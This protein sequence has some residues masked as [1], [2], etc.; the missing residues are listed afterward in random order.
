MNRR[1]KLIQETI[2]EWQQDYQEILTEK[3]ADEIIS[4][5]QGYFRL[6]EKWAQETNSKEA[7]VGQVRATPLTGPARPAASS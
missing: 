3:D 5:V 1:E 2:S 4:N 7:T 6:L